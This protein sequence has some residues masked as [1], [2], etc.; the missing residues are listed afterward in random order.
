M[1][2][3]S[4]EKGF[5]IVEL[6]IVV[7]VIG[8]LAAILI[9]TFVNLTSKAKE[10]SDRVFIK[11]LNTQLSMNEVE[12]GRNRTMTEAVEDSR[13]FGFDVSK[14]T[15]VGS[16][17]I[18]WDSTVDRFGLMTEDGKIAYDG[19]VGLSLQGREDHELW[20]IYSSMPS[21]QKYSIYAKKGFN[22]SGT[23]VLT[24]GFDAG[25]NKE[26]VF[27]TITANYSDS[28]TYII[29]TNNQN[30]ELTAPNAEVLHYGKGAVLTATKLKDSSYHEYGSIR[31]SILNEG[32]IK[33]EDGGFLGNIHFASQTGAAKL[34]LKNGSI[35]GSIFVDDTGTHLAQIRSE[36]NASIVYLSVASGKTTDLDI[37]LSNPPTYSNTFDQ[38]VGSLVIKNVGDAGEVKP[39]PTGDHPHQWVP[40][41]GNPQI[42]AICGE[43]KYTAMN[44]EGKEEEYVQ[45]DTEEPE[46]YSENNT[47]YG[48][49]NSYQEGNDNHWVHQIATVQQFRNIGIASFKYPGVTG[50]N[51]VF[52]ILSDLDF[53]GVSPWWDSENECWYNLNTVESPKTIRDFTF[54]ATLDG[55]EHT[56]SNISAINQTFGARV[57]DVDI[58]GLF[59]ETIYST[60]K[61]FTLSNITISNS[62]A[63]PG[64]IIACGYNGDSAADELAKD[65]FIKFNN[66]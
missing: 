14:L 11:N 12:Q 10:Q 40:E 49:F 21:T 62:S 15:P 61:N 53:G 42:C 59:D 23:T 28:K 4:K 36:G 38:E 41:G 48:F 6:V 45:Y 5:T 22:L 3:N 2:V 24:V 35:T 64:A 18:Y 46:P 17:H 20:R 34:S 52:E 58:A 63:K 37:E 7:A 19:G 13:L 8:I 26:D 51:A 39:L 31:N 56:L 44:E 33:V 47:T 60:F 50:T 29:C 25:D 57:N 65:K 27:E 9:P 32:H 66:C 43:I 16:D 54:S 30:I 55:K 1:K